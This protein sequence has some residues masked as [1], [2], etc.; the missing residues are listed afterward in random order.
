MEILNDL[1]N[2]SC[3]PG[4][5]T[6]K[7]ITDDIIL[8]DNFFED[9]DS[10]RNFF[11]TR[12]K[13]KCIPYQGHSKPG[14][15]SIFPIWTGKS[16]LEKFI[17]DNKIKTDLRTFQIETNLFYQFSECSGVSN[18]HYFPHID[19]VISQIYGSETLAKICLINLNKI[20]VSTKFYSYKNFEFCSTKMENEW[21]RYTNKVQKELIKFYN[22]ETITR[23]EIKKFLE[24][25][26]D[27]DVKLINT[28][29]YKPNQAIIYPANLFHSAGDF[30][31]FTFDSPRV[32]LRIVYDEIVKK[33]LIYS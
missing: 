21:G 20:S 28:V 9:F 2:Q 17:I 5:K 31:K 1:F 3:K 13:W 10:A 19:G 23:E 6:Y 18:S 4:Y 27:L 16:L 25:K 22:K 11:L 12:D 26:S 33:K 15:E 29:N 30:S 7:K 32:L 8:I 14:C 24:Q